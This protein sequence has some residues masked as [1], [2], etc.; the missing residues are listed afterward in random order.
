[1]ASAKDAIEAGSYQLLTGIVGAQ[2]FQH[3]PENTPPP[4]VIIGDIELNA[5]GGKDDPDRRGTLTIVSVTEGEER[6]P[7][8]AIMEQVDDRLDGKTVTVGGWEIAFNFQ[9]DDAVL[10]PDGAG[11]VGQGRYQVIALKN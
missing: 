10:A 4:V 9:S 1:M 7:L 3:V 2:L 11:Y 8:S 5:L 6:K